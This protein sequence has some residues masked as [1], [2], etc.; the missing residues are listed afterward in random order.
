MSNL[1]ARERQVLDLT[2]RGFALAQIAVELGISELT[3]RK[4]RS[5]IMRK[6]ELHSTAQLIASAAAAD[7]SAPPLAWHALRPRPP[8]AWYP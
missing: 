1:T 7:S 5:S 6:L 8:R 3:I 4:H 2:G